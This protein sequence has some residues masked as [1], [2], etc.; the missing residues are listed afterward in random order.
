[1]LSTVIL[2]TNPYWNDPEIVVAE[3]SDSDGG[4]KGKL[5][6]DG[7]CSCKRGRCRHIKALE[8]TNERG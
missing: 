2:K 3:W 8:A 1:M 4:R 7:S 6:A 5:Y